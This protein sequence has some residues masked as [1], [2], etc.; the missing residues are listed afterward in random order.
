MSDEFFHVAEAGPVHVVSLYLPQSMD[1]K[2]FDRLN[3]QMLGIFGAR[4]EGRWVLDLSGL[5]YMGS[6]ALGLMVNI[7]QRI[8]QAGGRLVLSGLSPR[9]LQIFKTCCM[10][11]L[12]VIARSTGEALRALAD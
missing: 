5:Y 6:S 10:E 2:E 12:F 11:R 8:L 3:E 4:P 1:S 9:L 7:R